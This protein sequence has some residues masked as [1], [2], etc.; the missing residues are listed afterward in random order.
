MN[1]EKQK[2][3]L[4]PVDGSD[5]SLDT[6]RYVA[7]CPQ[8]RNMRKVLLHVFSTLPEAYLDM[9]T[10]IR[11]AQ[12][13]KQAKAWERQ[14]RRDIQDFMGKAQKTLV[15]A[16]AREKDVETRIQNRHKGIARDIIKEAQK[17]YTA[18]V[19]RRRGLNAMRGVVVGSVTTKLIQK[20]DF[21]PLIIAG[22]NPKGQRILIGYDGSPDAMRAVDFVGEVTAGCDNEVSLLHVVRD[23]DHALS[24][25]LF[26]AFEKDSVKEVRSSCYIA[27]KKL[28]SW[29]L[30][31]DAITTKTTKG[32][33]SRARAIAEEAKKNAY[34]TVVVGRRGRSRVR[35]F[36]MGSVANKLIYLARDP[37]IWLVP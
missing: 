17:G 18:V 5:R 12:I 2:K 33:R 28:V 35:D 22:R 4:L 23:K 31:A 25:S 8:F 37:S 24:N 9:E 27:T 3:I 7:W 6:V 16:G 13:V 30:P 10:D 15:R 34:G 1:A 29:G 14:Q 11:S 32:R 36:F 26:K 20:I 21:L 19:T